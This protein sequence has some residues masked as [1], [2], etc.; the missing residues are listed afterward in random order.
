M[1]LKQRYLL[2]QKD[3]FKS[4]NRVK[5]SFAGNGGKKVETL[6]VRFGVFFNDVFNVII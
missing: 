2:N 6:S 3:I 4:L 1:S 5:L